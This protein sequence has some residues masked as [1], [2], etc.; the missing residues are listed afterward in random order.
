MIA[1]ILKNKSKELREAGIPLP[2]TKQE[3]IALGTTRFVPEDGIE[4][5]LRQYGSKK[6]P[7]GSIELASSRK[8]NVGCSHPKRKHRIQSQTD[9]NVDKQAYAE[10]CADAAFNEC[11]AHH[12][13]P[14]ARCQPMFEGKTEEERQAIRDR[15]AKFGIYYGNDARNI[16][17]LDWRTHKEVHEEYN[18]LDRHLKMLDNVSST[19]TRITYQG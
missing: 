12:I 3:A 19:T 4:R 7:N 17:V 8:R 5:V 10:I 11:E 13:M 9:P 2:K 15:D 14:L 6:F 1:N 18:A 16:M